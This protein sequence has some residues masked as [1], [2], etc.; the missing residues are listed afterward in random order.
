MLVPVG[1]Q[2]MAPAIVP[3]IA[4]VG[5][6]AV[7]YGIKVLSANIDQEAKKY[8]AEYVGFVSDDEFY[9][10][11]NGINNDEPAESAT[12]AKFKY[13]QIKI[14]RKAR[15][16]S[17]KEPETVS[18][19]ELGLKLSSDRRFFRFEPESL[20]LNY[21]KAKLPEKDND[22]DI[23]INITIESSRIDDKDTVH[24]GPIGEATIYLRDVPLKKVRNF[25][26]DEK[27]SLS[28]QWFPIVPRSVWKTKEKIVNTDKKPKEE[29]KEKEEKTHYGT[30][31]FTIKVKVTEYDDYGKRVK[32]FS[33][34]ISGKSA[35]L[36]SAVSQAINEWAKQQAK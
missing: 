35:T 11:I 29:G 7:E 34:F 33:E 2:K 26:E 4:A 23:D 13:R 32:E 28:S 27:K 8:T 25:G 10:R 1:E 3:I 19:I 15:L 5:S 9:E 14:I 18:V 22:L 16:I 30:G 24:C 17:D 20:K 12:N 36:G 21:A 31:N 6:I